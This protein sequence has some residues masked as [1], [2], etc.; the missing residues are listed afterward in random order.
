MNAC[1][2][3]LYRLGQSDLREGLILKGAALL[4]VWLEEPYRP[5]PDI[6]LLAVGANDEDARCFERRGTQWTQGVPDPLT[7][8][9]VSDTERQNLWR[10]YGNAGTL[11]EHPPEPFEDIGLWVRTLLD[12]I[13]DSILSVGRRDPSG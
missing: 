10:A 2:R 5:T 1:E 12:P 11:L 8:E 6:D 4:S 13:R 3:F 7:P 9:F